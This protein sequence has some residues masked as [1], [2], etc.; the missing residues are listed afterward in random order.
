MSITGEFSKKGRELKILK[1][2]DI[3]QKIQSTKNFVDP[4]WEVYPPIQYENSKGLIFDSSDEEE[5]EETQKLVLY[6]DKYKYLFPDT[7]K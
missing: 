2:D 7:A 4:A 6:N 1:C 3:E 5:Q